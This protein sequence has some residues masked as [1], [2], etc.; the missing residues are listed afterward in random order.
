MDRRNKVLYLLHLVGE[1]VD[2]ILDSDENGID[3]LSADQV[4]SLA[5]SVVTAEQFNKPEYSTPLGSVDSSAVMFE[6][7]DGSYVSIGGGLD[8]EEDE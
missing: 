6:M 5:L 2:N 8:D 3:Q 4:I 7:S 1:E